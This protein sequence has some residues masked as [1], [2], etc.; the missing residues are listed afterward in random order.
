[1]IRMKTKAAP[2]V[3]ILLHRGGFSR[4][5]VKRGHDRILRVQHNLL[6]GHGRAL[7]RYATKKNKIKSVK[8][9]H[10]TT[11]SSDIPSTLRFT[12]TLARGFTVY[13]L[14]IVVIGV[15][16]HTKQLPHTC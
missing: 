6:F 8:R 1:M 4:E 12:W 3:I 11:C 2:I 5:E 15:I 14:A 13:K 9:W 7:G 16:L 10:K